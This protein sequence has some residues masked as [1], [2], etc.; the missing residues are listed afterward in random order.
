VAKVAQPSKTPITL[1]EAFEIVVKALASPDLATLRLIEWLLAGL[2]WT[3]AAMKPADYPPGNFFRG[4]V[5]AFAIKNNTVVKRELDDLDPLR[6]HR[7][8]YAFGVRVARE[9]IEARLS[10]PIR[11]TRAPSIRARRKAWLREMPSRYP[12]RSG[13]KN[14]DYAK[15]LAK[16]M[17]ADLGEAALEWESIERRLYD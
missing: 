8:I 4:L 2:E 10:G 3:A 5:S 1:S 6:G 13:E 16:L 11:S 15:R 9:D 7:R 14:R 17:K 12:Q